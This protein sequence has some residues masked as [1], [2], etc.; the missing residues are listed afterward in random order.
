MLLLHIHIITYI[1]I[2]Y[3]NVSNNNN[4]KIGYNNNNK[5]FV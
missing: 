2:K 5:I 3:N 4:I 1:N